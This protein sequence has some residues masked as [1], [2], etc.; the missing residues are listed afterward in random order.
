MDY[1]DEWDDLESF[2]VKC[3]RCGT[4]NSF[5]D[6]K[7]CRVCTCSLINFCSDPACHLA[8]KRAARFCKHCGKPTVHNLDH[9]FEAEVQKQFTEDAQKLLEKYETEGVYYQWDDGCPRNL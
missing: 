3:A 6:R 1:T 4:E 5:P 9:V 8:N 7:N 2:I